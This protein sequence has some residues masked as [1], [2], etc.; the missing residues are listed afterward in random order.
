MGADTP[1]RALLTGLTGQDGSYLAEQLLAKGYEVHGLIRR[2]SSFN[3][4]RIEHLYRDPHEPAASLLPLRRP[5]RLGRPGPADLR[6][7]AGRDLQPRR[8]EPRARVLRHARVHHR[9]HR[10]GCRPELL[11]AIRE[12]GV[13]TRFYQA[14][15]SE[16]FGST[17]PP[18]RESTPFHPRSPY[19]V[20]KVAAYWIRRQLPRDLRDVRRQRDPLQPRVTA[21]RRDLRHAQ[22]HPRGRGDQLACR[23]SSTWAT[24]TPARLGLRPRLHRRDVAHAPA[25]GARRL[26]HRHRRDALRAREFLDGRLR[27]SAR[28]G[29]SGTSRSTPA[30][31]ARPRS[32][33][34]T[35][36]RARPR[37]SSAGSRPS[38]STSSSRSW[39]TPT[40]SRSTTQLAGR[41]ASRG[42]W[43]RP[44]P[45]FWQGKDVVVTGG[46]GFLG[47]PVVRDLERARRRRAGDPLGRAR[48]PRSAAVP[49]GARRGRHRHPPRR[50]RR[51]HRLQ[52]PQPGPAR[53][54]QP[55]MGTNVFEQC[56]LAGV[57][58]LVAACS[59]CAYPKFTRGAVPRG[60]PLERLPGGVQRP[61]R[62]GEEDAARPLRRLPA[63]VRLRLLRAGHRQPLRA[64]RQLRPRGLARDRGDD[65]Q[66]RR[67]AAERERAEVVLWGTGEPSREFLYVDDAARATDPRRRARR[68]L[69]SRSTSAPAW[70]RRSA[71]SPR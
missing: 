7:A 39:S 67:C 69:A 52:P 1:K 36:T 32:T 28:T 21:P 62:A 15:S 70:R 22:D 24:S 30:T 5:L 40:S 58:K 46:A 45:G 44:R 4:E 31:S 61:V 38:R 23:T 2:S 18:Q 51:R 19:A 64:G 41:A 27:T 63:P 48:P 35:A 42:R 43:P 68:F 66:V 37:R 26:R 14:S 60:R 11:E 8:P 3:T 53:P 17:P 54:R 20:A 25:G 65:P 57:A 47:K 13:E 9:R 33:R 59:V 16:I 55:A 12:S 49:R 29:T 10:R 6:D 56:R 34:C 50:Q 71:T